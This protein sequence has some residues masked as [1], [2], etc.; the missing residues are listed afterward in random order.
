MRQ[1]SNKNYIRIVCITLAV[2]VLF[3]FSNTVLIHGI[4][5]EDD[6]KQDYT[7]VGGN[8]GDKMA[9]NHRFS[10]FVDSLDGYIS[11]VDKQNGNVF[12]S[13]PTNIKEHSEL[14]G[15]S[16][17]EV[18][19]ALLVEYTEGFSDSKVLAT[20]ILCS[21][22]DCVSYGMSETKAIDN[23]VRIEY[24]FED[25]GFFIPIEIVL[26]ED[27]FKAYVCLNEI[28]ETGDNLIISLSLLPYMVSGDTRD[29]GYLFIPQ[30]CG[31][32]M[33]FNNTDR[34][35][36][37]YSMPIYG[38]DLAIENE[39][40]KQTISAPV[41]GA[42]YSNKA[43][44]GVILSGDAQCYIESEGAD[45]NNKYSNVYPKHFLRTNDNLVLFE[46]DSS[47]E[48][49]IYSLSEPDKKVKNFEVTYIPVNKKG[50]DYVDLATTYREYLLENGQLKKNDTTPK[51]SLDVYGA[52]KKQASFL[53]IPYQKKVAL[54]E[55]EQAE[56]IIIDLDKSGIE[57]ISL[58][59]NGWTNSGVNNE[60]ASVT[61][62]PMGILGGKK[63]LKRLIETA[64]KT[65]TDIVLT[66]DL[67]NYYKSGYG[68]SVLKDSVCNLFN[69]R[70][71]QFYYKL[72]T[73]EE[74][75]S[76]K[77]F[78]LLRPDVMLK[79]AKKQ[80]KKLDKYQNVSVNLNGIASKLYSDYAVDKNLTRYSSMG[81]YKDIMENY[82]EKGYSVTVDGMNLYAWEYASRIFGSES[83][84][85]NYIALDEAV[86]FMSVVLHGFI[87]YTASPG[88]RAT[89]SD[90]YLLYCLETGSDPYYMIIGRDTSILKNSNYTH[91]YS[92]EYSVYAE[93]IKNTYKKYH[94]VYSSLHDKTIVEHKC[95]KKD[96]YKTTYSDGTSI[97]V[98]YSKEAY[99]SNNTVVEPMNFAVVKS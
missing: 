72:S 60:K 4:E 77:A 19:S 26:E 94:E 41:F 13:T 73:L 10:L 75:E 14:K 58:K 65:N 24:S 3:S 37:S 56:K 40:E 62:K 87:P 55:F 42:C 8:Y 39:I 44:L 80:V 71:K 69:V 85:D 43:I 64:Q 22:T 30:G 21:Y 38:N 70:Q 84:A 78:Y 49:I 48:R 54:T 96:V 52:I 6:T 88:N 99:S 28:E 29:D 89:D 17:F 15:V 11:I 25:H 20:D 34:A 92:T 16:K 18:Q 67:M 50:S 45:T 47:N 90:E 35:S 53:G 93:D 98:N 12:S 81:Y 36:T 57:G 61:A 2:F 74:N 82:T 68:I 23:G 9:E 46:G 63:A 51:L 59:Y 1:S 76:V 91:L 33:Y 5:K 27:C 86:P 31:A 7:A 97:L 83:V 79:A 66:V 95:L 32:L